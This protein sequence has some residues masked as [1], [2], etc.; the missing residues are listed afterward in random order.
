MKKTISGGFQGE[1][2]PDRTLRKATPPS[3][4]IRRRRQLKG[5]GLPG[6]QL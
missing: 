5:W 6:E 4:V 1:L 2:C 3:G